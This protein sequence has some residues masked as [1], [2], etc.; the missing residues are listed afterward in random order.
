MHC[1]LTM[2]AT[3]LA[4]PCQQLLAPLA[5]LAGEYM[6]AVLEPPAHAIVRSE[7]CIILENQSIIQVSRTQSILIKI[8]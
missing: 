3:A 4:A 2:S 8:C 1:L 5:L 6:H 7:G